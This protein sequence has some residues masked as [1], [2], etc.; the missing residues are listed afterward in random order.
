MN[1]KKTGVSKNALP[2]SIYGYLSA[3]IATVI[4]S[5]NFI[6]A[7]D[8]IDIVPPIS[9]AFWRWSVATIVLLPFAI[10]AVIADWPVIK[11]HR[12]YISI[13]SILGISLFNALIYI[14]SHTTTVM[15]LSLI[16]ITFPV[17]IIILSRI[18]Y[19]ELV[20]ANKA[21]GVLIVII[22]IIVLIIKG[23]IEVLK[24]ID[25]TAGD[26]W[27]LLGAV[28]FAVYSLLLKKKPKQL[29]THSFQ[30]ITFL[31]GL[32]FLTP[33][34]LWEA[35]SSDFKI[36][37]I[38]SSTLYSILYIG[39]FASL[40]SYYLWGKAV[41]NIGP[42]QSSMIYYTLPIF[43]GIAAYLFLGEA[44]ETIQLLSMLFIVIGIFIVIFEKKVA[45]KI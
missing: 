30:L 15:N 23:D 14:A 10:K 9:L 1:R 41:E 40:V 5:G 33:F 27:M 18:F 43:S 13:T 2:L 6:V 12:L 36:Q 29:S 31:V 19:N 45:I 42:T 11:K 24:N 3:I 32:L 35:N 25:F 17:F 38:S 21:I 37:N 26:L 8:L 28:T 16:A 22:G 7:R 39:L 34:Y 4:W 44:V 20:T